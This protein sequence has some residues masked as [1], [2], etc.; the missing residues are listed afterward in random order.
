MESNG[1]IARLCTGRVAVDVSLWLE[2]CDA[3][4]INPDIGASQS[5]LGSANC[6]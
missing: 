5:Y 3:V 6:G 1:V 2:A 4:F